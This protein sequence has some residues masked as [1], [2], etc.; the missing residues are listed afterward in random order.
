MHWAEQS[1]ARLSSACTT[2]EPIS[3]GASPSSPKTIE[4][5]PRLPTSRAPPPSTDISLLNWGWSPLVHDSAR[6]YAYG[7]HVASHHP[8]G[9][10]AARPAACALFAAREPTRPPLTVYSHPQA[11]RF[12]AR[13]GQPHRL[14]PARPRM[15]ATLWQPTRDCPGRRRRRHPGRSR[16]ATDHPLR[17]RRLRFVDRAGPLLTY[18]GSAVASSAGPWRL[19]CRPRVQEAPNPGPQ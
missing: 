7:S 11:L 6:Q 12:A 19:R 16:R 15:R 18:P 8:T 3:S 5:P 17:P 9:Q 2:C 13:R 1:A 4:P 14:C 10:R